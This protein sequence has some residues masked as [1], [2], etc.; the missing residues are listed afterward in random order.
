M[1]P[2]VP[3]AIDL[4]EP[5][6]PLH[7][8]FGLRGRIP[9]K[10]FWLYGV[11]M[12]VGLYLYLHAVLGIA[13]LRYEAIEGVLSLALLWSMIAV[14]AKRWHDQDKSGWW[15]LVYLIPGIGLIWTLLANGFMR[16]TVGRNRFG[17]DLTGQL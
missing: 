8:L 15:A 10:I 4:A 3:P 5:M 11:G 7:I 1:N 2:R 17:D 16:G 13:G 12:Q 6:S 9:R 14:S